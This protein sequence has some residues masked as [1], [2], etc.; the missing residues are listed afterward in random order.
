ML[1]A[2]PEVLGVLERQTTSRQTASSQ[3][4]PQVQPT[5]TLPIFT[6]EANTFEV[7]SA[8]ANVDV[9]GILPTSARKIEQSKMMFGRRVAL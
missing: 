6:T 2:E 8:L 9:G 1:G 5:L 3:A 7:A 4:Q